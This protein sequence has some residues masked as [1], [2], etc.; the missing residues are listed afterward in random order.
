MIADHIQKRLRG[1][2][3]KKNKLNFPLLS[4]P[5]HKTLSELGADGSKKTIMRQNLHGHAA[6]L[7]SSANRGKN[8]RTWP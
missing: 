4:D 2:R 6:V 5:T 8:R 1:S 7:S 3:Q